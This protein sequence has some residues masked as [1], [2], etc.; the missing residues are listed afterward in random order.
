MDAASIDVADGNVRLRSV[1]HSLGLIVAA[2]VVGIGMVL[3]G[4]NLL[5]LAGVTVREGETIPAWIQALGAALQFVGFI[6]VGLL[7]LRWRDDAADLFRIDVPS[8]RDVG[9]AVL[10]LIGLFVILAVVSSV[11]T[12]L[13][14]RPAENSAITAGREQP[15]LL[16]YLLAVTVFFTAPAEELIFRGLVQG[17]FRRAYGV[18]LG[19][20]IASLLFGVV[21]YVALAGTGS[22]LVYIVVAGIL[23]LVL[24]ALYEKTQNLIVP[25]IV[26]GAYNT[27][28]FYTAYVAATGG[29]EMPNML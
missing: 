8:L 9:W 22:R 17:L 5:S 26:H 2:F 13:G 12:L 24:G 6:A 19:L 29:I 3:V 23:G 7:Y 14:I 10:G 4:F 20:V 11:I 1:L 21:H 28:I 18:K 16:L 27:V 15:V 25:I